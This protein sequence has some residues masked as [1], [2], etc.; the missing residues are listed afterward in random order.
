MGLYKCKMCGG[1]LET[2]DNKFVVTCDFC[3]VTQTI[4]SFD[5]EKKVTLFKRANALRFK[6]EFD[7]AS[8][9]YETIIA[10]FPKEAE[11]YWGL[12]LCKY[13]IEYVDDPKTGAKIPT[14]HRT[15]F[16]SILDDSDYKNVIKYSDVIARDIYAEEAKNIDKLQKDILAESNKA[17]PVDVFI[18]YKETSDGGSRTE[19]SVLAESIYNELTA[20][21]YSVFF[22]RITLE[23]KLGGEYEPI[24]FAALHS[25]KVMVHVTTSSENSDSIWVRN[26]WARFLSLIS[27]GQ[28]K[29]LI[30]VYKGITPYELPNELQ[31]LQ[32]QDFSKIG[33]MQ[34]LLRGIEKICGQKKKNSGK[35]TVSEEDLYTKHLEQGKIYLS[36]GLWNE[37]LEEFKN[38]SK[39]SDHSGKALLGILYASNKVKTAK[40]FCSKCITLELLENSTF[41]ELKDKV[42]D[43]IKDEYELISDSINS[44]INSK[45]L[46]EAKELV[47]EGKWKDAE[48]LIGNFE[49]KSQVIEQYN[50]IKYQYI[51]KKKDFKYNE[52]FMTR[53]VDLIEMCET[54]NDY[55]GIKDILD[56]LNETKGVIIK[57]NTKVCE[58]ELVIDYPKQVTLPSLFTFANELMVI[59]EK[60]K[61]IQFATNGLKV[62]Y[63]ETS[64]YEKW[65]EDELKKYLKIHNSKLDVEIVK[66]ISEKVNLKSKDLQALISEHQSRIN[67]EMNR[68]AMKK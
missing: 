12:L 38:A 50:T 59:K 7:K 54:I 10:D 30:P 22:S 25:A 66:S 8:A 48:K 37:A 5:N 15:E 16:S 51:L 3:G 68:L 55:P 18:C 26:E 28:K 49:N 24:I 65:L 64:G 63:S 36:K 32:G 23:S 33:A 20:L 42:D 13:G 67:A 21:G 44:L 52:Y 35:I 14:C 46:D 40:T 17:N 27:S 29:S 58:K 11:A 2:E 39:L 6:C 34:D 4:H 9:I 31:N 61:T 53:L 56:K 43:S 1:T 62:T 60:I 19:D 45:T 57:E 47:D 41:K